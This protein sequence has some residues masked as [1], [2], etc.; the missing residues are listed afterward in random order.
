[1]NPIL[2]AVIVVVTSL[3]FV[4]GVALLIM[5]GRDPHMRVIVLFAVNMGMVV[6]FRLVGLIGDLVS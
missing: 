1:M 4:N 6:V 3:A 5:R 2:L